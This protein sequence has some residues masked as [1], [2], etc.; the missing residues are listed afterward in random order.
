MDEDV[1]FLKMKRYYEDNLME[2]RN[3][4][5]ICVIINT[6]TR[7]GQAKKYNLLEKGKI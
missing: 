5:I 1:Y 7:F 6:D 2:L 4:N 3:R